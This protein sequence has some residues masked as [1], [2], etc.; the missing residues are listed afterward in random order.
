MYRYTCAQLVSRY[1]HICHISDDNLSIIQTDFAQCFYVSVPDHPTTPPLLYNSVDLETP[2]VFS[3]KILAPLLLPQ[4]NSW[5]SNQNIQLV[6]EFPLATAPVPSPTPPLQP[7]LSWSRFVA[8]STIQLLV[9]PA[10]QCPSSKSPC[11]Q[12]RSKRCSPHWSSCFW[13]VLLREENFFVLLDSSHLINPTEEFDP[14]L[15]ANSSTGF[16]PSPLSD[17]PSNPTAYPLVNSGWALVV[18]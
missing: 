1:L 11:D 2:L 15:S 8:L 18:E 14:S 13:P 16:A 3:V 4:K 5:P 6:P 12:T 9:S 7:R 10:G 17:T